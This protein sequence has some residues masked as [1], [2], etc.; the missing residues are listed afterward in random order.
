M[1]RVELR[2]PAC[3]MADTESAAGVP[4]LSLSAQLEWLAELLATD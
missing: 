4:Y 1:S 2:V 3:G